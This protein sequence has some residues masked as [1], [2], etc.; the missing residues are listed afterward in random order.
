MGVGS[1]AAFHMLVQQAVQRAA[2]L[3]TN[4]V[5]GR[6]LRWD[7]G[8]GAQLWLQTAPDGSIVGLHPHFEGPARMRARLTARI[9]RPDQSPLDGAFQALA[10]PEATEDGHRRYPFVFDSPAF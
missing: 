2:R 8:G 9:L 4:G 7:A 3:G 5:R 1:D 6:Y 10:A